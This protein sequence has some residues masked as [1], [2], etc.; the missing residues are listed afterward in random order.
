MHVAQRYL[1]EKIYQ[2][3]KHHKFAKQVG[4]SARDIIWAV[5][6]GATKER[7]KLSNTFCLA[8]TMEEV[9]VVMKSRFSLLL[10]LNIY[11]LICKWFYTRIKIWAPEKFQLGGG[12]LPSLW[13]SEKWGF[14]REK[15]ASPCFLCMIL[16]KIVKLLFDQGLKSTTIPRPL[17]P[18][19]LG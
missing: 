7:R 9:L 16:K 1:L 17:S 12:W 4:K 15:V 14:I 10:L 3:V 5:E 13:A 19:W 8:E 18:F 2:N 6:N 11:L